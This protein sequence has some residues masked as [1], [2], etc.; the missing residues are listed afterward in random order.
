MFSLRANLNH[1]RKAPA[2]SIKSIFVSISI[3]FS[4]I[5]LVDHAPQGGTKKS[6]VPGISDQVV[7]LS[8]VYKR[9]NY[10]ILT[11]Q[12]ICLDR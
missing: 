2:K 11:E 3:I 9:D 5:F 4:H 6:S 7:F 8:T 10:F 1:Q 12:I